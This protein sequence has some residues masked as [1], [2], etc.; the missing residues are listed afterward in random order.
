MSAD[1][2]PIARR[3]KQPGPH[4]ERR[5]NAAFVKTA[6]PGRHTDG[7]GLF[8]TVDPSGARRWLVRIVVRG[9]R[10]D[11]GLGSATLAPLGKAREKAH[12][13]R[14][15][16]RAGGDPL[17]PDQ[18]ALPSSI[19]FEAAAAQVHRNQIEATSRNG[20][21]TVQWIATL[22]T[23][24]FPYIGGKRV[25]EITRA[26]I[27]NVLEPIWLTKPE[28]ASRVLQ[29]MKAIFD[30]SLVSEYRIA[31]NPVDAVRAAL[32]RQ[33]KKVKHFT[34]IPWETTT[35]LMTELEEAAGVG[36]LG[37]VSRF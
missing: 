17:T 34:A 30:W 28:T 12:A 8:L 35:S 20:K 31:A 3:G 1:G 24:A 27:L 13:L 14:A 22:R 2:A 37:C 25:Y 33:K 15:V 6:P 4:F 10:R 19:T 26:D 21:H 7:G 29:R 11:I 18:G 23:Y 32:P 9:R 16:A 36:A 5:L